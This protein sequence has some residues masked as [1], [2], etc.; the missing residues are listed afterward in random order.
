MDFNST[1]YIVNAAFNV[2]LF[3]VTIVG[4]NRLVLVSITRTPSLISPS[5][6]L[7]FALAFSDLCVGVIVQPLFI[8]WKFVKYT[9]SGTSLGMFSS[10]HAF[11]GS[12]LCAVSFSNVTLLSV[13]RFLALYLHLR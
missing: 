12:V 4:L 1:L 3:I 8:T 7:L 9:F 5:N 10:V 13:D 6:I 2:P 11:F